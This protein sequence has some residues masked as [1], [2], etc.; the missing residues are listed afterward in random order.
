MNATLRYSTH[1]P[2]AADLMARVAAA[3]R[4]T[5]ERIAEEHRR[6]KEVRS[7]A[8]YANRVLAE[9]SREGAVRVGFKICHDD[10]HKQREVLGIDS[11]ECRDLLRATMRMDAEVWGISADGEFTGSCF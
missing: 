11:V 1:T 2:T 3:G 9:L 5:A 8:K 7:H 10:G 4:V 6:E